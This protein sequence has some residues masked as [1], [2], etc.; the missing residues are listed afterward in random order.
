MAAMYDTQRSLGLKNG[1]QALSLDGFDEAKAMIRPI[2]FYSEGC[3]L[4]GDL[5]L[6]DGLAAGEKRA[7]VLLCHGYTG[8]KDLYLPVVAHFEIDGMVP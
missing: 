2:E 1:A 6:P 4:R 8:V 5:Y 3:R 7:G